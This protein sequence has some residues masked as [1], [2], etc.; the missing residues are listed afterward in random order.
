MGYANRFLK[1]W[2]TQ[3]TNYKLLL[4][5]DSLGMLLDQLTRQYKSIYMTKLGASTLDISTLNS[6][7]S[8]VRMVLAIPAGLFIDRV[9]S[10]KRLYI[11][12]RLILLPVSLIKGL[13]QSFQ[14]YFAVSI[15]ESIGIRVSMPT[16]N[17]LNISSITNEDRLNG[18]VTKRMVTS[19][20]GIITP[21]FAAYLINF[22]GGLENV[23]SYRPLY[24]TQFTVGLIIFLVLAYKMEEPGDTST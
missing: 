12:S 24:L 19:I 5:S 21:L 14:N 4:F 23:D 10:I 13:A 16:W 3:S 7:V 15:W 1:F 8:L 2:K 22:F 18:L 6:I 9:K 17:I 11:L 20:L